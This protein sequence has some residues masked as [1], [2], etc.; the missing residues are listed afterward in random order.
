MAT[1]ESASELS[2]ALEDSIHILKAAGYDLIIVETPGIGQ[3]D[4]SITDY[5][6]LPIYVMTAEYG[7]P[8]QLEKIDMLDF[9]ELL[10]INKFDHKNSLD[11]LREVRK[12]YRQKS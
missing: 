4:A 1:R 11:A 10:V 6:D 12:Q 5:V 3:G 9:A 8:S 7:A 2:L